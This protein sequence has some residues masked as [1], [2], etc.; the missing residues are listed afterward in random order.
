VSDPRSP[1]R[2]GTWLV[3]AAL[4]AGLALGAALAAAR[5]PLLATLV[6][7]LEPIGALWT[8]AIRATVI[9]LVVSLLVAGVAAAADAGTV[10]QLGRRALL[11]FVGILVAMAAFVALAAPPLLARLPLGDAR[12]LA[13]GVPDPTPRAVP[14]LREWLVGLVPT[15]PVAAATDGALL[16]LVVFTAVFA[17]AVARLPTGARAA[18]VPFFRAAA[19]A[20]LVLVRWILALAPLGVLALAVP[21]GA[22]AGAQAAVALAS[23]VVLVAVLCL[24]LLAGLVALAVIGGRVPLARFARAAGPAGAVAFGTRSSLA[25]LP[26]MVDGATRHL[27]ASAAV[28]GVAIPLAAA[29]FKPGATIGIGAGTLFLARLHGVPLDAAQVATVAAASVALSFG[30]PGV[31]GGV[32]LVIAPALAAVG[33]P[34][35]G[36][37]ILLALDTVPDMFRTLVNA[38]GNLTVTALLAR[39]APSTE[40]SG[41]GA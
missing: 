28:T 38:T 13:V 5:S 6:A 16:P 2:P 30:I 18:L 29:L 1:R 31:P 40:A 4:V 37:G 32:I 19:D 14:G 3:L 33:L 23:F 34:P 8:N 22:R 26:A 17:L 20:L 24:A 36:L 25:A 10:G 15:N 9:P 11:A 35:E 39:G 27:G 7:V 12:A 41:A 21:L